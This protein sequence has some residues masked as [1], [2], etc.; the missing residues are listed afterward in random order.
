MKKTRYIKPKID[1]ITEIPDAHL[2]A[3]SD[4]LRESG[5]PTKTP[6]GG[7][8]SEAK[9]SHVGSNAPWSEYDNWADDN[10]NSYVRS[11]SLW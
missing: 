1:I 3:G 4:H 9:P 8:P 2:L 11:K 6:D 10:G 5:D 7:D